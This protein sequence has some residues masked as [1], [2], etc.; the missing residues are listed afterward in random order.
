MKHL[1]KNK[2]KIVGFVYQKKDGTFWY[3]FGKPSQDSWIEFQCNS[4]EQGIARVE[5]H[6]N[7]GNI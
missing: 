7:S 6:T 4:I 1:V 3:A 2:R 5:M